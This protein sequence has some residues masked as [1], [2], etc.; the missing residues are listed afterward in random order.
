[1]TGWRM[2]LARASLTLR[3]CVLAG[4]GF[5]L[6]GQPASAQEPN[7]ESATVT[8]NSEVS[9]ESDIEKDADRGEKPWAPWSATFA[10]TQYY[11]AAG[12]SESAYTTF[13]PTYSWTFLLTGSYNFDK[14][15][16]LSLTQL[17]TV[18]L[19]DSDTTAKRQQ[20]LLYDTYLDATHTIPIKIDSKH[21]YLLNGLAGLL[22]PTS[23]AS[24]AANM[25]LGA[26]ARV[27]AGYATKDVLHGLDLA[28]SVGYMRRFATA[29]TLQAENRFPC[30]V[31]GSD[32]SQQCAFLGGLTSTRDV[33][34]L[35]LDGNLHLSDKWS[36][37]VSLTFFWALARGLPSYEV[38]VATSRVVTGDTSAT[39]WRNSRWLL[40]FASYHFNDWLSATARATDIFAERGPDGHLRAPFNPLDTLFGLELDISFDQLYLSTRAH[41]H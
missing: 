20:F 18:E 15:T 39:H 35:G 11:A 14:H 29:G 28:A 19:T 34:L 38:P 12:L 16:S 31:S 17:G 21:G 7:A 5:W 36:A 25:I 26:R 30:N 23:K 9:E 32:S 41:A 6:C 24:Q 33:T 27:G 10:W 3:A 8:A 22:L 4:A 37:G 13:N 40:L 2:K 1:M